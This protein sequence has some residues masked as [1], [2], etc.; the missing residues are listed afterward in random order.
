MIVQL[1]SCDR[2][3]YK[4]YFRAMKRLIGPFKQI[5]TL[6]GIPFKGSSRDDQ[7]EIIE[8]GGLLIENDKIV[9][10]ASFS[11]FGQDYEVA[12]IESDM[13]LLPGF[14]DCHT[15]MC[16]GGTRAEDYSLRISGAAYQ[17]ILK[18]G[19]GIHESVRKTRD[20]TPEELKKSLVERA[21]RH[22]REG[23]TTV[24]VKSGY[25]LNLQDELKM[26]EI[27]VKADEELPIDIIATCLAAHVRPKEFESNRVYLDFIIHELFPLIK[28]RRLSN[29]IDIFVEE[30]AFNIEDSRYYLSKAK[31]AQFELT[32]HAD[33]FSTS[34]S[35]LAVEMGALSADH[36]ENTE[37]EE[38]RMLSESDTVGT[39]LPG[40]SLGLGM[41][42]APA[43][44]LLDAGACVAIASDWNPGSAPM[45][46][47]LVQAA[48]IGAYEKLST[49]E[50]FAGITFRAVKALSLYDRGILDVGKTADFVAFGVGDYREIL[51]HQGKLKPCMVWKE[52][53]LIEDA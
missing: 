21:M 19:G 41:Q 40:A 39:V 43:R 37:E 46:D 33:Q 12:E 1:L 31:E 6:R 2:L 4:F 22:L 25:G 47:L 52:G 51:W 50:T 53:K 11:S 28:S 42:F 5:L 24:E 16:W 20:S 3:I 26:L 18:R 48:L 17:Q 10:I 15:H 44:K 7:L 32:V 34:G 30:N 8:N 45:G 27:L 35:R 13:V 49:A 14:I 36:L 23:V 38:I 29:R 9:E